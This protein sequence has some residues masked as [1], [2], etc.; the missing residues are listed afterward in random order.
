MPGALEPVRVPLGVEHRRIPLQ[1]PLHV[2]EREAKLGAL[3]PGDGRLAFPEEDDVRPG[4]VVQPLRQRARVEPATGKPVDHAGAVRREGDDAVPRR[5]GKGVLQTARRARP[6]SG[7]DRSRRPPRSARGTPRHRPRLRAGATSAPSVRSSASSDAS[8]PDE[9][10][11]VVVVREV[12]DEEVEGVA[13]DEPAADGRR[14]LVDRPARA[15]ANREG[16]TGPLG[17]E[18]VEEEEVL[19]AV[20]G[21]VPAVS[22]RKRRQLDR[23]ARPPAV[24]REVDRRRARAP[25][26]RAPRRRSSPPRERCSPLMPKIVSRIAWRAPTAR[27]AGND[28]PYSTTRPSPR[29]YQT[30]CGMWWTSGNA[31]VAIDVRQT[32]VSDG[33]TLVAR[34]VQPASDSAASAGSRPAASPSSRASGVSPS[35]TT[36]TS[37]LRSPPVSS[38]LGED[39]EACMARLGPPVES[40][41]GDRGCD[42]GEVAEERDRRSDDCAEDRRGDRLDRE[43]AGATRRRRRGPPRRRRSPTTGETSSTSARAPTPTT[44]ATATQIAARSA[45][46]A[47][48]PAATPSPNTTPSTYQSRT[49]SIARILDPAAPVRILARSTSARSS[50]SGRSSCSSSSSGPPL[51]RSARCEQH[52]GGHSPPSSGRAERA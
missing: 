50:Q 48:A 47:A 43:P 1:T 45:P 7:R 42:D 21:L 52:A 49:P 17:L 30:R 13:G 2:L 32:G 8:G 19:R 12:E 3:A 46:T 16:R 10:R 4:L 28:E 24:A 6:A 41:T 9:V 25:R 37:F 33:K 35:M 18:E 20:D 38:V 26:P 36:R 40:G 11:R 31:P 5:G 51:S 39:P 15:G 22:P 44:T 29:W 14:V 23:V 27:I 34:P